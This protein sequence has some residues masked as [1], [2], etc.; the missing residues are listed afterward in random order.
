MENLN[1]LVI[2]GN[3]VR[4]PDFTETTK[5]THVCNFSIASNR[6]Y[7]TGGSIEKE[8]SFFNVETW[9]KLADISAQN[10]LKGRGVRIVGR[11]KQNRWTDSEGKNHSRILIVA[12]HVECRPLFNNEKLAENTALQEEVV[13][14]Q[15]EQFPSF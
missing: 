8:V 11:L 5:G 9:G 2:E 12:D 1:S 14:P 6:N 10:C 3:V 7:K 13:L 15:E 4:N